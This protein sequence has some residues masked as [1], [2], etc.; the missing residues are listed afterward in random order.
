[1]AARRFSTV[2]R[3]AITFRVS[4]YRVSS[5][6]LGIVEVDASNWLVALGEGLGRLGVVN[7]LDRIACEALPNG[8]I[9]V[10][11]VRTGMGF[12]VQPLDGDR[13]EDTSDQTTDQEMFALDPDTSEDPSSGALWA[14][15]LVSVAPAADAS[16]VALEAA[17]RLVP[18]AG[19]AVLR[20]EGE[21]LRFDVAAGPHAAALVD[22]KIPA[23][24]GFVG[25]SCRRSAAVIANNPMEDRRFFPDVDAQTGFSTR[26]VLC[27]PIVATQRVFG[28]VELVNSKDAL[29]FNREHLVDVELIA[30]AL[31]ERLSTI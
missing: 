28:C 12:V 24:A 1:M 17:M 13:P 29:G 14:V 27:A 4:L 26:S 21:V 18:C 7:T 2:N 30:D 3:L 20:I 19:G 15:E 22:M 9:L 5:R 23:D 6:A 8:Q 11:D 16:R 31:A 10:R 25:F